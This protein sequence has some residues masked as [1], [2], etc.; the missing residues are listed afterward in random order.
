MTTDNK[1]PRNTQPREKVIEAYLVQ[2]CKR[3]D[4][5]CYKFLSSH[6]GV[7]DRILIGHNSKGTSYTVFVEVKRPGGRIRP[8][9]QQQMATIR[10][11]GGYTVVVD[12]HETV[13]AL[14]SAV[15]A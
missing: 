2:Q 15:F 8:L 1:Q 4:I 7:P 11:H 13:D 3:R 6:A 10:A 5:L 9:Q 14:L 12:S